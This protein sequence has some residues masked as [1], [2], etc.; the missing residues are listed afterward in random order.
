[1]SPVRVVTSIFH[2]NQQNAATVSE[3]FIRSFVELMVEKKDTN[4]PPPRYLMFLR[5]IT[6]PEGRHNMRNQT[7][8]LMALIEKEE[9]LL[10]MNTPAEMTERDALIQ[11]ALEHNEPLDGPVVESTRRLRYHAELIHLLGNC[12]YGPNTVTETAVREMLPMKVLL[13]HLV[14]TTLP[15][16]LRRGYLFIFTEAYLITGRPVKRLLLMPQVLRLLELL[17][18][19]LTNTE[20]F[21]KG[22]GM[23]YIFK[24][25]IP[26]IGGFVEYYCALRAPVRPPR[27]CL[28]YTSDAADD[29]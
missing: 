25:V 10:L 18:V 28:L 17:L 6:M 8:V 20:L 13:Q 21:D 29:M 26:T 27:G 12:T 11:A 7:L 3:E 2:D 19:D 1:M 14:I 23:Q 16:P 5:E 22:S 9:T 4:A 15:L 24:C